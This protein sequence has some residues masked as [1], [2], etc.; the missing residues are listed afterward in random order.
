VFLEEAEAIEDH[1]EV[2][3]DVVETGDC[4][5][6]G[7]GP[8]CSENATFSICGGRSSAEICLGYLTACK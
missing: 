1:H 6:T 8:N 3:Q 7:G 4:R 5:G 2:L